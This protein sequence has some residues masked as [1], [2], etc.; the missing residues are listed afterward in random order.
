MLPHD[1]II[2]KKQI[3]NRAWDFAKR[4]GKINHMGSNEEYKVTSS[5]NYSINI[6]H[7]GND[8][9]EAIS[10][11]HNI[12]SLKFSKIQLYQHRLP[13]KF[14]SIRRVDIMSDHIS[15]LPQ[16]SNQRQIYSS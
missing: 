10:I 1:P 13:Q 12:P 6:D 8:K 15:S 9:R 11:P 4:T 2:L 5:S 3:Q 16:T 7:Y 14:A